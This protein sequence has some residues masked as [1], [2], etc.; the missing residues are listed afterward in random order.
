MTRLKSYIREETADRDK[1]NWDEQG[2]YDD[3]IK[4]QILQECKP[5]LKESGYTAFCRREKPKGGGSV[6][7]VR[8]KIRTDRKPLSTRKKLAEIV[9]SLFYKYHGIKART[10]SIFGQASPNITPLYGPEIYLLFP[11]G[12]FRYVWSPHIRDMY[13]KI[14]DTWK[15]ARDYYIQEPLST[16]S[17]MVELFEKYMEPIIK[18]DYM[19]TGLDKATRPGRWNNEVMFECKEAYLLPYHYYK[20]AAE[21]NGIKV[22]E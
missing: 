21:N 7:P 10:G 19:V 1:I 17:D 9:D 8:K 4:K 18:S 12:N 20:E 16:H 3:V 15:Q 5:F 13:M 2:Y 6:Y 22:I 11:I 14:M